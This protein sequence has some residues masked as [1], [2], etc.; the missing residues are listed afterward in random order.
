[1]GR[2]VLFC[3]CALKDSIGLEFLT[4]RYL[5]IFFKIYLSW[6]LLK[7][8]VQH[9]IGSVAVRQREVK[10][11][12]FVHGNL[13]GY[14]AGNEVLFHARGRHNFQYTFKNVK[15]KLCLI[16]SNTFHNF[17]IREHLIKISTLN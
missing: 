1:M 7:Q 8:S 14:I 11:E 9:F 16:G 15:F 2:A 4:F 17:K 10:K 5:I 3:Y 13:C 6:L 12:G